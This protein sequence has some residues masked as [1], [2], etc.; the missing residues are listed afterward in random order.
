MLYF[1]QCACPNWVL[2]SPAEKNGTLWQTGTSLLLSYLCKNQNVWAVRQ[3]NKLPPT[4]ETLVVGGQ[5]DAQRWLHH[6]G[7]LL[8]TAE[9]SV[10]EIKLHRKTQRICNS[11]FSFQK[12][13][14]CDPSLD[15]APTTHTSE[16][17]CFIF[18]AIFLAEVLAG[19]IQWQMGCLWS[20]QKKKHQLSTK[21][22]TEP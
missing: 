12:S 18:F 22:P 7:L 11:L 21:F 13:L 19:T 10:Q 1:P 8:G 17:F 2:H 14:W 6:K 3:E 15:Q 4:V 16:R 9:P 5:E 20:E